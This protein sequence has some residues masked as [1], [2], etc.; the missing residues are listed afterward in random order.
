MEMDDTLFMSLDY[1]RRKKET[2]C[3]IAA[4]F[5]CHIVTLNTVNSRILVGI[6]LLNLFVI[7]L[8]K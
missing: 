3:D 6:L 7:A 5:A 2:P 8:D 1:F 4:Y